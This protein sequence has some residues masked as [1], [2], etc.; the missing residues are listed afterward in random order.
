M[1]SVPPIINQQAILQMMRNPNHYDKYSIRSILAPALLGTIHAPS[2]TDATPAI[3]AV[4]IST[5][6][7]ELY[8]LG[9]IATTNE[10]LTYKE[11][12]HNSSGLLNYYANNVTG[13]VITEGFDLTPFK[14]SKRPWFVECVE[15]KKA[16]WADLYVDAFTATITLS[17]VAP[18]YNSTTGDLIALATV[19]YSTLAINQFLHKLNVTNNGRA[20]I[21]DKNGYMVGFSSGNVTDGFNNLLFANASS[22][23]VVNNILKRLQAT[24]KTSLFPVIKTKMNIGASSY[25]VQVESFANSEIGWTVLVIIPETDI[26][27]KVYDSIIIVVL[28]TFA[29]LIIFSIGSSFLAYLIVSPLNKLNNQMKE[30]SRSSFEEVTQYNSILWEIQS[31]QYTFSTMVQALNSIMKRTMTQDMK[32]RACVNAVSDAVVMVTSDGSILQTNQK[33]DTLFPDLSR[34]TLINHLFEELK[35]NFF[36][37]CE[38]LDAIMV[39]NS[40]RKPVSI[41]VRRLFEEQHFQNEGAENSEEDYVL[42]IRELS[43]APESANE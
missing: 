10:V 28:V 21:I 5:P 2:F 9:T 20:L 31:I 4:Y 33:F 40:E 42:V 39:V 7:D 16:I 11:V 36:K 17:A 22:D 32:L 24:Y 27:Q 6:L 12:L 43:T 8:F 13:E 23:P 35:P 37:S 19:D 26:M 15:A 29:A 41:T 14:V 18:Y 3:N 25:L 30:I 1:L 38:Q 34:H